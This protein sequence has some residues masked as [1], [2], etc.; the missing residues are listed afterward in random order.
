MGV[1]RRR[2]HIQAGKVIRISQLVGG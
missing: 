1:L 2:G